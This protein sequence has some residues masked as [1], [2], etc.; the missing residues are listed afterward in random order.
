MKALILAIAFAVTPHIAKPK[1]KHAPPTPPPVITSP[2]GF[3]DFMNNMLPPVHNTPAPDKP[4]SY[5]IENCD[6]MP[7]SETVSG[8]WYETQVTHQNPWNS[9]MRRCQDLI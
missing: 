8:E 4:P 9:V 5:K 1:H 3:Q 7:P 6:I 2:Q